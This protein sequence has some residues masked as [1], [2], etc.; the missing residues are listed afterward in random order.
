MDI[1]ISDMDFTN[2]TKGLVKGDW[3]LLEAPNLSESG[4]VIAQL[5]R[6]DR[7]VPVFAY[8]VDGRDIDDDDIRG[9]VPL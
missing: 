3:Y 5:D 9:W 1:H 4:Y 8:E 7:S 6:F 2:D